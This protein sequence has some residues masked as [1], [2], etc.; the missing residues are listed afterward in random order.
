MLAANPS[1]TGS[2]PNDD[3]DRARCIQ[4]GACGGSCVYDDH[5]NRA[6]HQRSGKTRQRIH[7]SL[8]QTE[9][10]NDGFP[11]DV[12]KIA[13]PLAEGVEDRGLGVLGGRQDAHA[14]HSPRLLRGCQTY[15]C[16]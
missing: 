11:V 10:E 2:C 15:Q 4:C 5:V 3:W 9:I 14:R 7:V 13:K 16:D 6:S 1:R 12:A 8:G